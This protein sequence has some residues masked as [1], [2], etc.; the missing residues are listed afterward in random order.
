MSREID[1]ELP[2]EVILGIQRVLDLRPGQ[3]VDP[4]D[5]LSNDF[6]PVDVLN[7][8]FPDGVSLSYDES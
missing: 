6:S 2:H 8:L 7:G 4:L 5:A 1:E 3:D